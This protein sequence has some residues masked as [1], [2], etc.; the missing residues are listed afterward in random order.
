MTHP[1]VRWLGALLAAS[2]V[3][4][5]AWLLTGLVLGP[6]LLVG[7]VLMVNSGPS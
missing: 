3:C 2:A 7:F 4:Y 6:V 5:A 1:L